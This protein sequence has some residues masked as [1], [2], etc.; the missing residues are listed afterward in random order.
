M[1]LEFISKF[2]NI[3]QARVMLEC[4]EVLT[5]NFTV[6]YYKDGDAK[7]AAIDSACA[8]L[9]SL[10]EKAPITTSVTNG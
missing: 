1:F 4:L 2:A 6:A 7:D 5:K 8:Y 10:K 3:P 9:Q